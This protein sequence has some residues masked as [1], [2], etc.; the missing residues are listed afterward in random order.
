MTDAM[1]TTAWLFCKIFNLNLYQTSRKQ[2][3]RKVKRLAQKNTTFNAI[4]KKKMLLTRK[5]K[6]KAATKCHFYSF[7]INTI[8]ENS[9][10]YAC[11]RLLLTV[12]RYC[13][14]VS[15]NTIVVT[16]PIVLL[17]PKQTFIFIFIYGSRERSQ[18]R[19]IKAQ[20]Y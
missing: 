10:G 5:V 9:R 3:K 6:A 1:K 7:Q 17:F 20:I 15:S 12:W 14:K 19:D 4:Q 16:K 2:P 8:K 13:A 18:R 11:S